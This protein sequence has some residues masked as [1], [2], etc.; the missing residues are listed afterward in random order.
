M[1]AW[2]P[3][4]QR[5]YCLGALTDAPIPAGLLLL[6]PWLWG[7]WREHHGQLS[8]DRLR[9]TSAGSGVGQ[10][11]PSPGGRAGRGMGT[12]DP[13]VSKGH[14]TQALPPLPP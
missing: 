7:L 8:G 12:G 6:V 11:G 2:P 14:R 4:L 5:P 10:N 9:R 3:A 13:R 1:P